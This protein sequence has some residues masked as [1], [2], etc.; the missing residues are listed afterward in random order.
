MSVGSFIRAVDYNLI[1]TRI[2]KILGVGSGK[3]GYGQRV[4]SK[5]V[6]TGSVITAEQWENLRLDIVS[7]RLHQDGSR[8]T[9]TEVKRGE[10]IRYGESHPTAQ[11]LLHS[12]IAEENSLLVG[13]GQF[14]I[15][16]AVSKTYTKPWVTGVS[17]SVTVSFQNADFARF[18]FNSGGK[19]R[20]STSRTGGASTHQNTV[21]TNLLNSLGVISFGATTPASV[22]FYS[23]TASDQ[24]LIDT[25]RKEDYMYSSVVYSTNTFKLKVRSNVSNNIQGGATSIIFT[26]EWDDAYNAWPSDQVDGTLSLNVEELR[27][28]GELLPSDTFKIERPEYQFTEFIDTRSTFV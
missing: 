20:I 19:I 2:E 21:W 10:T 7:A 8:T 28:E 12:Q 25:A 9:L 18:F 13:N 24:V 4:L 1:Q 17:V 26:A 22:N 27:A 16:K 5:P 15:E 14:V 3:Y 11:Y 23:L 6:L